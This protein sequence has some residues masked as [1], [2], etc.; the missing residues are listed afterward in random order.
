M[1]RSK[2]IA[3]QDHLNA[4]LLLAEQV[5]MGFL[6]YMLNMILMDVQDRLAGSI[7]QD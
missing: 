4:A 3:I 7:K 2:L 6:I 1:D 5:N